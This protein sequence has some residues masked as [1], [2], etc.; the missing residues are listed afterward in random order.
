MLPPSRSTPITLLRGLAGAVVGA[1][2]GYFL[3]VWALGFG[4][5]VLALPG[6]LAGVGCGL[7]TGTRSLT[8]GILAGAVA[9]ALSVFVEWRFFPFRADGSLTY[10]L[11]HLHEASGQTLI[12]IVLGTLA[13]FWFGW[14]RSKSLPSDAAS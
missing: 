5:I 2:I 6:A 13:G 4:V 9:L 1:I 10:F 14:Q 11:G 12:M 8:A 7:A 3:F